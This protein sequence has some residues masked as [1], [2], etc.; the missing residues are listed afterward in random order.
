MNLITHHKFLGVGQ[1]S[2]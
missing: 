2:C 1:S